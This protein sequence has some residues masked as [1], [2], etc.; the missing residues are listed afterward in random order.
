MFM[1]SHERGEKGSSKV[2][3][4]FQ[5]AFS[6]GSVMKIPNENSEHTLINCQAHK[7]FILDVI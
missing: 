5:I 6:T 4:D 2:G 3:C 1:Y 7:N